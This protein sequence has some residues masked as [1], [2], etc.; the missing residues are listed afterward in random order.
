MAQLQKELT[1]L[2]KLGLH[3]R[4]AALLVQMTNRFSSE[5]T[6]R[7]NDIEINAK[8]IMGIMMLAA[9]YGS[10]LLVTA[11]GDD[12]EDALNA[13]QEIFNRKFEE[14]DEGEE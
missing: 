1:V 5:V 11:V 2:N 13:I 6:L 8:S 9:E 12:A 4:P 3:A 14:N 7:K 10:T